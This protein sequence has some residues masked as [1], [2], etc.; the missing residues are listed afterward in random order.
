MTLII[1]AFH[2]VLWRNPASDER[3]R[4]YLAAVPPTDLI[5]TYRWLVTGDDDALLADLLAA[6]VIEASGEI[7]SALAVYEAVLAATPE[8]SR[9]SRQAAAAVQRLKAGAR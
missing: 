3:L 8:D 5:A 4:I 6:R 1:E 9:A 2:E 7:A